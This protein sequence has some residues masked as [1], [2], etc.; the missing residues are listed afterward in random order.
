MSVNFFVVD[1]EN[2]SSKI[3]FTRV[4]VGLSNNSPILCHHCAQ[5]P[6]SEDEAF[7]Q[8]VFKPDIYNC[9]AWRRMVMWRDIASV[10]FGSYAELIVLILEALL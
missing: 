8:P 4:C 10:D 2:I 6:M 1:Q 5:T 7:K 9:C 3:S